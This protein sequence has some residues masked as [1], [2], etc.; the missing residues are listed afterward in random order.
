MGYWNARAGGVDAV[1]VQ[2]GALGERGRELRARPGERDRLADDDAALGDAFLRQRRA[3]GDSEGGYH[4]GPGP[5][6][7]VV[8][9]LFLLGLR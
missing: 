8:H 1:E 7:D 3:A 4:G 9:A 2:L 6:P 5:G